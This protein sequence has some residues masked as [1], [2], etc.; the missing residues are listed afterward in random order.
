M[1]DILVINGNI[2]WQGDNLCIVNGT[3]AIDQ[4]AYLQ[5]TCDLG[6][7]IFYDNYGSLLFTYIGKPD[8]ASNKAMI[9]TEAKNVLL[10]TEGIEEVMEIKYQ[11]VMIE[12]KL[13]PS[14]YAKY[15]YSGQEGISEKT[16]KFAI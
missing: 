5:A 1:A 2:I 8:N 11:R 10:K 9:E 6:E 15:R 3:D 13:Y 14:I 7:S 12:D 4:E 16:F